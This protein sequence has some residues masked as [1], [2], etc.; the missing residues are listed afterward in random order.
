[1]TSQSTF[2][3][4]QYNIKNKKK[5]TM[6]SFLIDS[7][8]KKY[9][10]LTIQKSWRNVCVEVLNTVTVWIQ[11]YTYRSADWS[12]ILQS[13]L[14]FF[15]IT[16]IL[17]WFESHQVILWFYLLS[18]WSYSLINFALIDRFSQLSWESRYLRNSRISYFRVVND[19]LKLIQRTRQIAFWH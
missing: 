5:S 4:L 10:L 3:I 17:R 9:D 14:L 12:M 8:I 19:S 11:I 2:A 7:R 16:S 15:Y 1:M 18:S 6:I 13:S